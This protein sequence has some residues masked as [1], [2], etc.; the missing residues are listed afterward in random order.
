MENKTLDI[1]KLIDNN[2]LINLNRT[3]QSKFITKIKEKF[4]EPQQQIFAASFYAYLNYNKNDFV[5]VL[6]DIWKW[7]GF[8]RKEFCKRV[9]TKHFTID[10]DYKI[11]TAELGEEKAA[12]QTGSSHKNLDD[13]LILLQPEENKIKQETRGRKGEKILIN[14]NTFKKLSLKSNTKKAD[15]IHDYYLKLEET[16]QETMSE[17]SHELRMQLEQKEQLLIEQKEQMEHEHEKQLKLDRHKILTEQLKHKK[18]IYTADIG[19]K[20]IKIGSSGNV[21]VRQCNLKIVFGECIYLDV[22]ECENFR[23]VEQHILVKINEYK[24]KKE[25]NGH[26][27]NEVV[28]LTDTFNYAQLVTIIKT[29]IK[30]YINLSAREML[31]HKQLNFDKEKIDLINKLLDNGKSTADIVLILNNFKE[32]VVINKHI[33]EEDI[34]RPQ[35]IICNTARGRKIQVISPDNLNVIVKVYNSMVYALKDNINYDKHGIQNAVKNNTI[36]K[37]F[38]WMFVPHGEN[39]NI[40][41]NIQPTVKSHQYELNCIVQLNQ[42]KTE[43]IG[44]YSGLTTVKKQYGISHNTIEKIIKDGLIFNSTYFIKLKDCPKELLDAYDKP[45]TKRHNAKRKPLKQINQLTKEER[46]FESLTEASLF[47]GSAVKTL[48]DTIKNKVVLKGFF[49]EFI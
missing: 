42:L 49:W 10:V 14:I 39:E 11:F 40:V 13:K 31:K 29:E 27:S 38:R 36:Y 6:N 5:I 22:F 46:A 30:N 28:Q 9:L 32:T 18:C 44:S 12:P 23:E 21:D 3:Y 43:I 37:N 4:T 17:E 7:L 26:I 25:I 1:V 20:K 8:E 47:C 15:E 33:L 16:Y 45:L 2:P 48:T 35:Q 41:K 24:Y 19:G 34:I